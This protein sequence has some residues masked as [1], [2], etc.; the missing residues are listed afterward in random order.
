MKILMCTGGS[1]FAERAVELT[2]NLMDNDDDIMIFHVKEKGA[3]EETV[4]RCREILKK[5]GIDAK[6]KVCENKSGVA[7]EILKEAENGYDL[8]IQ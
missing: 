8:I 2:A 3:E 5:C 6:T 1:K 7:K 4:V